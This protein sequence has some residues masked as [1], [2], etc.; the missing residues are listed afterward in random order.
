MVLRPAD[1]EATDSKP[2]RLWCRDWADRRSLTPTLR[3]TDAG[4]SAQGGAGR[5]DTKG[6]VVLPAVSNA[7]GCRPREFEGQGCG[8]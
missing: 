7:L 1:G 6:S 3:F 8:V 4:S 5:A 2:S